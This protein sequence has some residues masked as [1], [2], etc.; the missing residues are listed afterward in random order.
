M[1]FA[2]TTTS[3]GL[4]DGA[5][6]ELEDL[7]VT[8]P[9]RGTGLGRALVGDAIAGPTTVA[10]V[11]SRSSSPGTTAP[12]S[13]CTPTTAGPASLTPAPCCASPWGSRNPGARARQRITGDTAAALAL[14]DPCASLLPMTL[15]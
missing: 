15:E 2:V 14:T 13:A 3:F 1:G 9:A 7:Y 12:P 6:A 5:I 8:P 10:A 11:S 4:E